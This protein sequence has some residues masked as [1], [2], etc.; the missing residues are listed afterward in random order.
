[1]G[2]CPVH[3]VGSIGGVT[4]PSRWLFD[5]LDAHG[6]DVDT[7]TFTCPSCRRAIATDGFC[8]EHKTGFV[9]KRAYF[10]W[11]TYAL[12]HGDRKRPSEIACAVCRRNAASHGWCE[13]DRI[14]MIAS[15][16]IAHRDDYERTLH[17]LLIVEMA[18]EAA[19]RC[20]YC[21]AAI[22]TDTTCPVCR[23]QYRDGRAVTGAAGA[24]GRP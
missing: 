2:W 6:H 15:V 22:V 20:E 10:S 18:N 12:A 17:A 5:T 16:A 13:K 9:A 3:R 23:I 7:T 11:L 14:G 21:A 8:D 4:V 24:G 1:M 19:K